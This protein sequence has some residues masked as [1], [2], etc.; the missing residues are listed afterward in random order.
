MAGPKSLSRVIGGCPLWSQGLAHKLLQNLESVP[1]ETNELKRL[2]DLARNARKGILELCLRTKTGHIGPAFSVVEIL[3]VLYHHI[4]CNS[5]QASDLDRD[6]VILSKGHA[7]SALYTILAQRAWLPM[8]RLETFARDGCEL[9]HHPHFEPIIGLDANTGSLGHGLPIG[10]GLAYAAKLRGK[11]FRT[12]VILGDG[13]TN[14][15]SNWEAAAFASHHRLNNL[16]MILDAN[17]IQAMGT[18]QEVLD[19][20]DH[21]AKWRSFGWDAIDVDGNDIEALV[22]A[23]RKPTANDQPRAIVAHTIKGKGVSFME[24][25]LSWHYRQPTQEDVASAYE[26]LG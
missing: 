10:C 16:C 25:Q 13:E 17:K 5:T 12:F 24:G 6:R 20:I 23:L 8:D 18:T 3:V 1:M 15:G 4:L 21:S 11:N 7:C 2:Q 19:P 14:E 9:G 26:E 22:V